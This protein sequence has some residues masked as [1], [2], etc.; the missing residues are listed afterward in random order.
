MIE[1]IAIIWLCITNIYALYVILQ[2]KLLEKSKDLSEYNR[3]KSKKIKE[4]PKT[5]FIENKLY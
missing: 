4:E 3:P 1:I 5:D 2:L